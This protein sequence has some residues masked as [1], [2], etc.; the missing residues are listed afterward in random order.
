MAT[1]PRE[2]ARRL[3]DRSGWT[4]RQE[5]I[6]AIGRV[7]D[8]GLFALLLFSPLKLGEPVFTVGILVFALGLGGWVVALF[9]FKD[10]PLD[11]PTTKGLYRIS[12]NPQYLMLSLLLLG[13][14]IATGSW[15]AILLLVVAE[16]IHHE[17]ILAEEQAC[18][19]QYGD[20]YRRYME[21]VPR[22][23]LFF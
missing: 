11:Q 1:F 22:Y 19:Q 17:R 8:Y 23:L 5:R 4:L 18:L 15:L 21:R 6:R 16:R 10:T 2:V 14:C 20:A 9:N 13:M 7:L 12:R 3:F